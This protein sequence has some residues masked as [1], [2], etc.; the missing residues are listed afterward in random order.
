MAPQ[1]VIESHWRLVSI[2]V[3]RCNSHRSQQ[4]RLQ[5]QCSNLGTP[6]SRPFSISMNESA[7][8][9]PYNEDDSIDFTE[10]FG[11]LKRGLPAILGF[12]FVGLAV[13][14]IAYFA[15]SPFQS[16][17]TSTRVVFSFNGFEKGEYPDRS[18]FQADDLRSPEVIAEALK[19]KGLDASE[20]IQSKVRAALS[21]EGII[22]D[23]IIK[24]RDKLRASGQTPRPYIPD[25]YKLTLSLPRSFPITPRERGAL[26]I[27]L[28]RVYQEKFTRTYLSLPLNFGKAFESLEGADYF[29]YELVLSQESQNISSFLALMAGSRTSENENVMGSASR[30]FRSPRTNLSFSDLLKENQLFTQIRLN[31]TLGLIRQNGLSKDRTIALLKMD[32]YLKTL[33]DEENKAM[34]EEKVVMSLLKQTQERTQNYVLGVKSMAGQQRSDSP[35]VDQGLVDSLLAN[36]ANNFLVRRSLDASLRTRALQSQKAIMQERRNNMET[37]I[38]SNSAEKTE[39]LEQFQKSMASLKEVYNRM[40]KDIRTTY[41]DFQHQQFGDAIR[42][43]M[44]PI[45]GSFYRGLAIAGIAGLG[46]G[47]VAGLGLS[48][49]GIGLAN[50][51]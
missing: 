3:R 2:R 1:Y 12:A 31:E 42:V 46:V 36:D 23:S 4:L 6:L 17:T 14:A 15:T 19:H 40:I 8:S 11:R 50:R 45:T 20:G 44:Q 47:L 16:V 26:L 9:Q 7:S 10:L 38:K 48:L 35:V 33:G 24:E 49:L 21:I 22:P 18:K 51:R 34:E 27:E 25:E 39:V 29:D 37:F 41:E 43:S 32:Y 30:T 13:A 28:I 5:S